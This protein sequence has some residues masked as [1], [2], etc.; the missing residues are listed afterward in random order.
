MDKIET[1]CTR[2]GERE[3]DKQLLSDRTPR[4]RTT[5][6]R[7][8]LYQLPNTNLSFPDTA[9]LGATL[10][11]LPLELLNLIL[12]E[13]DVKSFSKFRKV[14]KQAMRVADQL[15]IYRKVS[16]INSTSVYYSLTL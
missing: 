7:K 11:S 6:R 14:N 12:G 4:V 13:L 9:D 8:G 1:Q 3:S 15:V 16:S 2:R 5:R 10:G